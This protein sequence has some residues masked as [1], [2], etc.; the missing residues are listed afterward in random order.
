MQLI[1]YGT[2]PA[3][4]GQ[5]Q[6]KVY[7]SWKWTHPTY[8]ISTTRKLTDISTVEIDPSQRMADY[9]WKNNKIELKW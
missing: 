1:V 9:D 8:Q 6:R 5:E 7:E 4:K 2:K 3:E